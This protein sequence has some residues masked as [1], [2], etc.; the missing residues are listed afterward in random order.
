MESS[1][2]QSCESLENSGAIV[3]SFLEEESPT[4]PATEPKAGATSPCNPN[5]KI[6]IFAEIPTQHVKK[7][8]RLLPTQTLASFVAKLQK[9]KIISSGD[10]GAGGEISI[11]HIASNGESRRLSM[12]SDSSQTIWELGIRDQVAI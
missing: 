2:Q 12:D 4:L 10:G 11:L 8:I 9:K 3:E 6:T 5:V 1:E 7:G